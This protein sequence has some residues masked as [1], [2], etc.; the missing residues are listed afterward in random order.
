MNQ[1]YLRAEGGQIALYQE[2]N[3]VMAAL[4]TLRRGISPVAQKSDCL[5]GLTSVLFQGS[6]YFAYENLEHQVAVDILGGGREKI[7]LTEGTDRCKFSDLI[8]AAKEDALVLFY[9]CWNPVKERFEFHAAAPYLPE[10]AGQIREG[11]ASPGKLSYLEWEGEQYLLIGGAH[12]EGGV[13]YRWT[14][15]MTW[16]EVGEREQK[17]EEEWRKL[18]AERES[19]YREQLEALRKEKENVEERFRQEAENERKAQEETWDAWQEQ[20]EEEKEALRRQLMEK[21]EEIA[22]LKSDQGRAAAADEQVQRLKKEYEAQ[23]LSAKAQ[24]DELAGTAAE[25]QRIG[26]MWREKCYQMEGRNL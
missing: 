20:E 7:V 17:Q 18:Q 4:L 9:Q 2:G 11:D 10:Q 16:E 25:L 23:L 1:I 22:I 19:V 26:K 24:Y 12:P 13:V 8:L 14:G 5:G 15:R 6:I 21:E 3:K